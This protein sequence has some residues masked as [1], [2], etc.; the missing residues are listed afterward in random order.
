MK[1]YNHMYVFA[2]SV[3]SCDPEGEDLTP[4][5]LKD[6]AMFRLNSTPP[7]ELGEAFGGPEDTYE[8]EKDPLEAAFVQEFTQYR[9]ETWSN[10][11]MYRFTWVAWPPDMIA[12]LCLEDVM[13][14]RCYPEGGAGPGHTF[15][16]R[17]LIDTV[18]RDTRHGDITVIIRQQGG[19]DI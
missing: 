13:A 18:H 10:F 17:P 16:E 11:W 19:Y 9:E 2:V 7:N 5:Q 14:H 1:Y 6:A 12:K 8:H 15:Y 3:N 4:E